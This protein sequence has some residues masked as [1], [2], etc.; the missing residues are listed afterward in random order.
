MTPGERFDFVLVLI[1]LATVPT[2]AVAVPLVRMIG[3]LIR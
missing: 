3:D 1:A 2:I